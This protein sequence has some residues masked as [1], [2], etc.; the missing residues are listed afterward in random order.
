MQ[1]GVLRIIFVEYIRI[2]DFLKLRTTKMKGRKKLL[3]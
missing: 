1:E 3:S 2:H